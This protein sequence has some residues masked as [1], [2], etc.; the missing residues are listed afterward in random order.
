MKIRSGFV[1]NSSSS[2]FVFHR[3]VF[4]QVKDFDEMIEKLKEIGEKYKNKKEYWGDSYQ[5]FDVQ[6]NYL[7]IETFH[8]PDEVI[9][10]L[11]EYFGDYWYENAYNIEG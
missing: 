11:I 9:E 5:T 10:V 6:D 8:A 1:S 7:F 3:T 4:N 2:S